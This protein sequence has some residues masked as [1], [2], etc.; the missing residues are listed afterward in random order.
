MTTLKKHHIFTYKKDS[1][2]Y[3]SSEYSALVDGYLF[4]T[5]TREETDND[6]VS[7]ET[8]IELPF[9][10]TIDK[11]LFGSSQFIVPAIFSKKGDDEFSD[12]ESLPRILF[13]N[14]VYT[15]QLNGYGYTSP[16]QNHGTAKFTNETDFLFFSHYERIV[17]V[18]GNEDKNYNFGICQTLGHGPLPSETLY[19]EYWQPYI[20]DLYDADTRQLKLKINLYPSDVS[21]F[22]FYDQIRIK[23]RLYRVNKINY[24]PGA[25]SDVELILLG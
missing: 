11:P 20:D 18:T 2:D 1:K 6:F 10:P 8:K 23:N 13:D 15:G 3:L 17:P 5:H 7:G 9:A 16:V 4:G 22:R 21:G 24:R 25:M 19:S 14:G 12:F